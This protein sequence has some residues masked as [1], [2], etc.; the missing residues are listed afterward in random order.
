MS[1]IL[2]G[3]Q[4]TQDTEIFSNIQEWIGT[5][6]DALAEIRERSGSTPAIL[7]SASPSLGASLL[8]DDGLDDD[9]SGWLEDVS[10]GSARGRL[11]SEADWAVSLHLTEA[12]KAALERAQR[13]APD[14]VQAVWAAMDPLVLELLGKELGM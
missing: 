8:E 4:A 13:E 3:S 12:V 1:S 2:Y 11:L 6:L 10:P 14:V 5:W 7:S 9:D